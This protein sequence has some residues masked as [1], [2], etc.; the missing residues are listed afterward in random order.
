MID[1]SPTAHH[2]FGSLSYPTFSS[3]SMKYSLFLRVVVFTLLTVSDHFGTGFSNSVSI[4]TNLVT[5]ATIVLL[6]NMGIKGTTR[7]RRVGCQNPLFWAHPLG[8]LVLFRIGISGSQ[9]STCMV[10]G[11]CTCTISH[12]SHQQ[13]TS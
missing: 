3:T 2:T 12:S 9:A 6:S 8:A 4:V 7:L 13:L 1:Y 10:T 11:V 5:M